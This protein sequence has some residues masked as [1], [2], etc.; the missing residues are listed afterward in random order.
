MDSLLQLSQAPE[1]NKLYLLTFFFIGLLN[2][3]CYS[4]VFV[5]SHNIVWRLNERNLIGLV[6]L[7]L[8][9]VE[10]FILIANLV[11]FLGIA[12]L[13]RIF[14]CSAV[15]SCSMALVAISIHQGND[16]FPMALSAFG[17][18]GMVSSVGECVNLGMLKEFYSIY[19]VGFTSGSGSSRIVAASIWLVIRTFS[20]DDLYIWI[21]LTSVGIIY[22]ALF[23]YISFKVKDGE[24]G[25]RNVELTIFFSNE[26]SS[27]IVSPHTGNAYFS[28][29]QLVTLIS[30]TKYFAAI[31]SISYFCE[32]LITVGLADRISINV[33]LYHNKNYFTRNMYEI[34]QFCYYFG[35]IIG[36]SLVR[37]LKV[38]KLWILS[39]IQVANVVLLSFECHFKFIPYWGDF[40]IAF[41]VGLIGGL[42]YSN[43]FNCLLKSTEISK[44]YKEAASNLVL[45]MAT[46]GIILASIAIILIDKYLISV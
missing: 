36:K 41:F 3:T 27:E 29:F 13:K 40:I 43:V 34:I 38:E 10:F 21:G 2:N 16:Y 37:L 19:L 26:V 39:L 23:R 7:S 18:I 22:F 5:G 46:F 14:V 8:V 32:A 24:L 31:L 9:S 33:E 17:A 35:I 4:M 11:Y 25:N 42:C 15:F 12:N 6:I 28:K 30:T 44:Y 1:T 45:I 20:Q